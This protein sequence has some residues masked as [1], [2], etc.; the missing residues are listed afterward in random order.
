ML[1]ITESVITERLAKNGTILQQFPFLSAVQVKANELGGCRSCQRGRVGG[2]LKKLVQDAKR[3][4]ATMDQASK[5][6]LKD[7]LG[8]QHVRIFY[9]REDNGQRLR[10]RVDF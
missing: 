1:V 10:E 9:I 2:E 7:L 8:E 4:I 6:K 3:V 5:E